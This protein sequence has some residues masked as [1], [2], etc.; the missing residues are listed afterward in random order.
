MAKRNY[1]KTK[2]RLPIQRLKNRRKKYVRYHVKRAAL[3]E[4]LKSEAQVTA[5]RAAF[6][7]HLAFLSEIRLLQAKIDADNKAEEQ[8]KEQAKEKEA[9]D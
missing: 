2:E 9:D 3:L 4:S 8:T 5:D 1:F 6:A 7:E